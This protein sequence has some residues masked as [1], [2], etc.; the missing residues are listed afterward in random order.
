MGILKT[1]LRVITKLFGKK[2]PKA[3]VKTRNTALIKHHEGLRLNAYLDPV[4]IWTIG[5]G[6]TGTA[7]E[8]MVITLS[9]AEKLLEND[10][11][12]AESAIHRLVE[13]PLNQQQFDALASFIFN[14][15]VG[16]FSSSTLL[17]KLNSGDY[18]GAANEFPRWNKGT[19]KGKK[20]I[21]P[22]LVRRR[23]DER[24]LFLTEV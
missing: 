13:V 23:A 8:G 10:L 15:G 7:R 1:I 19:I 2:S 17:K 9:E 3:P 24:K 22:G 21:L 14:V 16:N 18:M 4:G 20:V 6:H 5:W 11:K 12:T